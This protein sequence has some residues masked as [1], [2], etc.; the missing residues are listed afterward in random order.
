M[1]DAILYSVSANATHGARRTNED[2]RRAAHIL[3]ND[4]EW[5]RWSNCEISR[6][7]LIDEATV[8]RY[9]ES[10]FGKT[11]VTTPREF[12]NKHGTQSTMKTANIGRRDM[13]AT[14]ESNDPGTTKPAR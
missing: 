12:T 4:P 2:K 5:C 14:R 1:R 9:R 11:E 7:C 8:R 3:F 10:H 13:V 6:R